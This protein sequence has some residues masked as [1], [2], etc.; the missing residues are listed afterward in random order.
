MQRLCAHPSLYPSLL[1]LQGT[2]RHYCQSTIL[3]RPQPKYRTQAKPAYTLP[4]YG[5]SDDTLTDLPDN[6][7]VAA[8]KSYGGLIRKDDGTEVLR[9]RLRALTH[10]EF[11]PSLLTIEG[12]VVSNKMN[13]SVVVAARRKAYS[14]KLRMSYLKTRRFM[15]HDE[16]DLCREGDRVVIRSCRPLSRHKMHVVVQNFGDKTRAEPDKREI[17]LTDGD[18]TPKASQG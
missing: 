8:L 9:E 17:I 18:I 10:A 3:A 7:V 14:S 16:F 15:A 5:A 2:S 1:Q 12:V 6:T 13:K 4:Y 11:R